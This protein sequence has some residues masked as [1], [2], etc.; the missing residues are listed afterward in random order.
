MREEMMPCEKAYPIQKVVHA[1]NHYRSR[2][3]RRITYEYSV[4]EGLNDTQW[5]AEG[6]CQL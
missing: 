4:I 3:G 2:S 5:C 1:C 6:I